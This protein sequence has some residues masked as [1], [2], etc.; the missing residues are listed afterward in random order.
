MLCLHRFGITWVFCR[1]LMGI[2]LEAVS[3][4]CARARGRTNNAVEIWK[5]W[6][7]EES[8]IQV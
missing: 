3:F 4:V 5:R 8:F 1:F 7:R 2:L 6:H